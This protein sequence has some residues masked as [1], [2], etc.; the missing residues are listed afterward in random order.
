M[1]NVHGTEIAIGSPIFYV[2]SS[3]IV[4]IGR[5]KGEWFFNTFEFNPETNKYDRKPI[6]YPVV[7]SA[8]QDVDWKPF[9]AKEIREY[10]KLPRHMRRWV[11]RL[12]SL[13]FFPLHGLH[14]SF[15]VSDTRPMDG[16]LQST[17]WMLIAHHLNLH[18]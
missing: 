7:E 14:G 18:K 12:H 3:G 9:H 13:N 10:A 4:R 2:P 8:C 1:K 5:L 11:R 16:T 6:P 17:N 15:V